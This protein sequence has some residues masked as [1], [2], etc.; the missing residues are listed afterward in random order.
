MKQDEMNETWLK[1]VRKTVSEGKIQ[2][3]AN[4]WD[5]ISS[6]LPSV[7][8]GSAIS[9]KR[10]QYKWIYTSIAATTTL[11]IAI[12]L[13]MK[14]P[15][16]DEETFQDIEKIVTAI[17]TTEQEPAIENTEDNNLVIGNKKDVRLYSINTV[18]DSV[19]QDEVL[20]ENAFL[21]A[22]SSSINKKETKEVLEKSFI[23]KEEK[24]LLLAMNN[25]S[26]S[27]N[28]TRISLSIHR[29][30]NRQYNDVYNEKDYNESAGEK[31]NNF[32]EIGPTNP[33]NKEPQ[34]NV[35]SVK[36]NKAWS[37]GLSL[38]L[39]HNSRFAY[40]SGIVF[41]QLTSDVSYRNGIKYLSDK[42][43]LNYLGVP[44][45]ISYS[46]YDSFRWQIYASSGIMA[47]RCISAK[48]GNH[49]FSVNNWQWSVNGAF[50]GQYNLSRSLGIYVEPGVNY[51]FDDHSGIKS[52]RT[53]N[54]FSLNVNMGIRITK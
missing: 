47:E 14:A 18:S 38:R 30:M 44:L 16:P 31:P 45:R 20:V 26:I 54:P 1:D 48:I 4:A 3:P 41:S 42:Q 33:V 25:A 52:A 34:N 23:N 51:Y 11:I 13:W 8:S 6:A 21:V 7:V 37:F 46:F 40:E 28:K 22:D 32:G 9:H 53:A 39:M 2:L 19:K 35:L 15:L 29:G 36:S 50:G 43:I 17:E 10:I 5:K 24:S 12:A 27:A 49:N